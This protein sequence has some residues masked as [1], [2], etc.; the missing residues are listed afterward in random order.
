MP[1]LN[2]GCHSTNLLYVAGRGEHDEV[3][4]WRSSE[5]LYN[6]LERDR[7]EEELSSAAIMKLSGQ[8][9]LDQFVH[10]GTGPWTVL[11][12]S[13]G[14]GDKPVSTVS[15]SVLAPQT[16]RPEFLDEEGWDVLIGWGR[17]GT[18]TTF[19]ETRSTTY[20]PFG[21]DDG[22]EPLVIV[23]DAAGTRDA[24]VLL[25]QEFLLVFELFEEK[26]TG[27]YISVA[28]DGTEVVVA[29]V[30][31][32]KA[33]VRSSYLARFRALKQLDLWLYTETVSHFPNLG[34][35]H[36]WSQF[37]QKW[38]VEDSSGINHVGLALGYP[39]SLF[40]AKKFLSP[41]PLEACNLWEYRDRKESFPE[42]IIGED[43]LG[44]PIT[45]TC[46]ATHLANN[47]GKNPDAPNYL[48]P[49]FFRSEVMQKY[50]SDPELYTV[51][52]GSISCKGRWH[53]R[54]DNDHSDYV[55]AFLGDLGSD[56]PQTER[57]YWQG[58]NIAPSGSMSST[59]LRRSILAE[60]VDAEQ[61]DH[62]FKRAYQQLQET[63]RKEHGWQLHRRPHVIDEQ[64][65]DRLHV[66]LNETQSEFEN[67]LLILA[68]LL[69]DFLNDKAITDAV[70]P[71]PANERSLGKI[72]RFLESSGYGNAEDDL[73][74][75]REIQ[76][77]RSKVSAHT[78]GSTYDSY[79]TGKLAGR[80]KKE[81]VQDL[82]LRSTA[83]L[84]GWTG[85]SAVYQPAP[86]LALP[87]DSE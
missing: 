16:L 6:P 15:Y 51:T 14:I 74:L 44:R 12:D 39:T 17:P 80:T 9:Y 46:N 8:E 37:S 43:E 79:I 40:R 4:G 2:L 69:V 50:Y 72:Q 30:T 76:D 19:G 65:I 25:N 3:S 53:F 77:L 86:N 10:A 66:P 36:D 87:S 83:M 32:R 29:E 59:Y 71:G 48:T 24:Q 67:Q 62:K 78:K 28:E 35:T 38:K 82:L 20:V 70:G 27:R 73:I 33:R 18:I 60:W 58:F 23:T 31:R 7:M 84:E 52:E 47:F 56:L 34:K 61:P 75:L 1:S 85:L 55:A 64:I 5:D 41:P 57:F 11:Y 49:V 26:G 42:F 13:E 68:K 54:L 22:W 21:N 81:L 63:W 45:F